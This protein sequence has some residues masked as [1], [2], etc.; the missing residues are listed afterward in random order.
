MPQ[1]H[2]DDGLSLGVVTE[3]SI[4]DPLNGVDRNEEAEEMKC[5]AALSRSEHSAQLCELPKWLR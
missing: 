1:N 2:T 3:M 4:V 5:K